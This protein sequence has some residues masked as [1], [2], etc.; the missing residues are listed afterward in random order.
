MRFSI[1]VNDEIVRASVAVLLMRFQATNCTGTTGG[2]IISSCRSPYEILK[3]P[4]HHS[5]T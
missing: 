2:F 3:Y 1:R 5:T 4:P